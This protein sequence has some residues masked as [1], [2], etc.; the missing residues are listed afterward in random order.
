MAIKTITGNGGIINP[1]DW[2]V[3]T[4]IGKTKGSR[5]DDFALDYFG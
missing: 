1:A 3:L 4:W 5:L 2:H